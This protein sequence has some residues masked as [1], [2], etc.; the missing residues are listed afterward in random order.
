MVRNEDLTSPTIA[1][2]TDLFLPISA[3]SMSIWIIFIPFP[4]SSNLPTDLS[5]NLA[6]TAMIRSASR[7]ILFASGCPCIP[8]GPIANGWF[9]GNAPLPLK[10]VTT[11]A[12]TDSASACN[13]EKAPDK[14]TPPPAIMIG[15]CAASN[16]STA[17]PTLAKSG[18]MIGLYPLTFIRS[19]K[20]I[21]QYFVE[22]LLEYQSRLVLAVRFQQYKT[23]FLPSREFL[24]QFWVG[25]HILCRDL[26]LR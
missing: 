4:N 1:K 22:H 18:S 7:I 12:M 19:G 26:R 17:F 24:R 25:K 15:F 2:S 23:T 3:G 14:I 20:L 6:P 9:S 8:M 13:S 10:V 21:S 16:N 5:E 11:G